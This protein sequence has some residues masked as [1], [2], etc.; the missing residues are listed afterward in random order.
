MAG[1]RRWQQAASVVAAGAPGSVVVALHWN[2][3]ASQGDEHVEPS[4]QHAGPC[5][6]GSTMQYESLAQQKAAALMSLPAGEGEGRP[7]QSGFPMLRDTVE[8]GLEPTW[9]RP[10]PA[11]GLAPR[12]GRRGRLVRSREQAEAVVDGAVELG[13]GGGGPGEEQRRQGR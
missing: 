7:S 11:T 8:T 1:Q 6:P 3:A 2:L 12:E 4:L 5:V 9:V 13:H 10:R